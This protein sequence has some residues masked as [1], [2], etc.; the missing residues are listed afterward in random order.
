MVD[1][2]ENMKNMTNYFP[3]KINSFHQLNDQLK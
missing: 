1:E 3:Q 2:V